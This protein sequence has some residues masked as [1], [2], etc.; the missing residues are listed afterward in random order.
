[1]RSLDT[2]EHG[3]ALSWSFGIETLEGLKL[4]GHNDLHSLVS[5]NVSESHYGEDLEPVGN[6]FQSPVPDSA[7]QER[8][9]D[10]LKNY[11]NISRRT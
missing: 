8:S 9:E 11:H 4:E 5:S 7:N 6:H 1:M 2:L 10:D 3:L